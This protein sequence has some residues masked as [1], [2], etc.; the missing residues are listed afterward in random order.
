M[1]RRQQARIKPKLQDDKVVSLKESAQE[2]MGKWFSRLQSHSAVH[3]M[4]LHLR[5][6]LILSANIS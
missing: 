4:R 6:A 3:Q 1:Q 2:Q 5:D